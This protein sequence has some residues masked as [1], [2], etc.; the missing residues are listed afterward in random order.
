MSAIMRTDLIDMSVT[1]EVEL[2]DDKLDSPPINMIL[3]VR[4]P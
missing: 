4:L 3:S 1:R 2:R